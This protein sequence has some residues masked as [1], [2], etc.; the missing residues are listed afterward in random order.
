[1]EPLSWTLMVFA[2]AA[3]LSWSLR[4]RDQA[5]R[6]IGLL[7]CLGGC[8]LGIYGALPALSA[9]RT[10]SRTLLWNLPHAALSLRLDSLAAFFLILLFVVGALAA[11]AAARRSAGSWATNRPGEHWLSLNLL[12]LFCGVLFLARNGVLLLFALGAAGIFALLL[13]Q[14]DWREAGGGWQLWVLLTATGCA[15]LAAVALAANGGKA[16]LALLTDH[17]RRLAILILT[18][19]GCGALIMGFSAMRS[20]MPDTLS[21]LW[22]VTLGG[23]AF[24][25]A[26]RV[27]SL[28]GNKTAL[29]LW[30]GMALAACGLLA[31]LRALAGIV[32]GG[33]VE[34]MS[35]W[36]G[37]Y[38]CG[39]ATVALGLGCWACARDAYAAAFPAFAAV[40]FVVMGHAAAAALFRLAMGDIRSRA[41]TGMAQW[42]GSWCAKMPTTTRLALLGGVGCSTLPPVGGYPG[43]V[44]IAIAAVRLARRNNGQDQIFLLV[45]LAL[46]GVFSLLSLVGWARFLRHLRGQRNPKEAVTE[47]PSRLLPLLL[48]AVVTVFLSVGAGQLLVRVRPAADMLA[49][50]LLSSGAADADVPLSLAVTLRTAMLWSWLLGVLGWVGCALV[51]GR[52]KPASVKKRDKSAVPEAPAVSRV[53]A[54]LE[55]RR[56]ERT[57]P[58]RSVWWALALLAVLLLWRLWEGA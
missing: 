29:P 23:F 45:L 41:G 27:L 50:G 1:M 30:L 21:A 39:L 44:L 36:A 42:L 17:P 57:A 51:F 40:L 31:L 12:L 10:E 54:W 28:A 56:R 18:L 15:L 7:G 34:S 3:V 33:S 19:G 32:R 9:Y 55:R 38:N 2:G 26:L 37:L 11:V 14:R 25:Y 8:G 53:G 46:L 58:V 4:H 35:T 22:N 6:S 5:C 20:R 43:L 47:L 52:G 48:L 24:Y 16:D 13:Y 49:R